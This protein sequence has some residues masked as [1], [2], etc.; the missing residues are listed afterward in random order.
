MGRVIK[1]LGWKRSEY[2][3]FT[4]LFFGTGGKDPNNRGL[5]RKHLFEGMKASLE[6]LQLD[7]VVSPLLCPLASGTGYSHFIWYRTSSVS[8]ADAES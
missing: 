4:K 7:Y 1:E 2:V 8:D 6:R 3:I 5:S